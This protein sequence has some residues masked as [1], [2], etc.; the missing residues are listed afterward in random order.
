MRSTRATLCS[1]KTYT[2]DFLTKKVKKNHGEI[3]QY[4]VE[5]SHPAI[6]DPDTF[7]LVQN[8]IVEKTPLTPP[9]APEQ[10]VYR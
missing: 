2:A 4:Y 1:K 5:N 7:A 10:P 9:N 6:I 3:Q 8:E